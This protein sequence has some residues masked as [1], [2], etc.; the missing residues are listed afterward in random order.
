MRNG[1]H[2]SDRGNAILANIEIGA[3]ATFTLPLVRQRRVAI[4]ADL[5][6]WPGLLFVSAH[7]DTAGAAP[8]SSAHP[9]D[10]LSGAPALLHAAGFGTGRAAQARS[11]ATQLQGADASPDVL[12]GADLN[13]HA[14]PIDPALA[15]LTAEGYRIA[16]GGAW[17][18]TAHQGPFRLMLDHILFRRARPNGVR[19]GDLARVGDCGWLP[20]SK[21]LGS[22]H[23]PLVLRIE[24]D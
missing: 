18:H 23:H 19:I 3:T 4:A 1:G 17:R 7:L 9:D 11:L 6:D 21:V 2:P 20:G 10:S 15:V 22:D 16:G 14:G 24:R 5:P 12:I 8:K 13:T